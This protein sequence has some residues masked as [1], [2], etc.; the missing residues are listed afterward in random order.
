[1][2]QDECWLAR[3]NEVVEFIQINRR[4][5]SR[6]HIE[7][8]VMK[9]QAQSNKRVLNAGELKPGRVHKPNNS[10]VKGTL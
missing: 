1:M 4:N 8:H 6:C 9:K 10:W 5:L 7:K 2:T 3:Y